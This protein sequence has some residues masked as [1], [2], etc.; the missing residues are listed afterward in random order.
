MNF[1][2]NFKISQNTKNSAFPIV[3]GNSGLIISNVILILAS[4]GYLLIKKPLDFRFIITLIIIASSLISVICSAVSIGL[5]L[6]FIY[7]SDLLYRLMLNAEKLGKKINASNKQKCYYE[8]MKKILSIVLDF[9]YLVF[10]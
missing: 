10:L 2:K 7:E 8:Y 6:L 3:T 5:G 1:E 4:T 9:S